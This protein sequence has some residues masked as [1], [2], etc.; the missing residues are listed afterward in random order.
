VSR[1][2]LSTCSQNEAFRKKAS[3][4]LLSL[5]KLMVEQKEVQKTFAATLT[6]QCY[7]ESSKEP[8]AISEKL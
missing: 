4:V 8:L 2:F 6:E 5:E 1:V 7:G 3:T